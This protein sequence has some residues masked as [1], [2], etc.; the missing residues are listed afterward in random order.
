M[1]KIVEKKSIMEKIAERN[2]LRHFAEKQQKEEKKQKL[3]EKEQNLQ[4]NPIGK[5][6]IKRAK[7]CQFRFLKEKFKHEK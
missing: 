1:E 2:R 4:D 6:E 3:Q 7:K 5:G